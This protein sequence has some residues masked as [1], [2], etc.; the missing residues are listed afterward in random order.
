MEPRSCLLSQPLNL[1]SDIF[2]MLYIVNN[3]ARNTK[4]FSISGVVSAI[5]TNTP[6]AYFFRLRTMI[7]ADHYLCILSINPLVLLLHKSIIYCRDTFPINCI[8][9]CSVKLLILFC[10]WYIITSSFY[11]SPPLTTYR[12]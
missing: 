7:S 4:L 5:S 1:A 6:Y 12:S 8:Q 9:C 3:F 2:K 11:L 10:N